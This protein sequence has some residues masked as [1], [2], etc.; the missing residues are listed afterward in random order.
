MGAK[1]RDILRARGT[2]AEALGLLDPAVSDDRILD[3]MVAEP[4]LVER[5][6]VATPKGVRLCRPAERVRELL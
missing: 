6:I 1:P 2:P 5:P 3:A 4:I